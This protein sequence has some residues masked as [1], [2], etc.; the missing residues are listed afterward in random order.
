MEALRKD[1]QRKLEEN[2]NNDMIKSTLRVIG[3][4]TRLVDSHEQHDQAIQFATLT[5]VKLLTDLRNQDLFVESELR[6]LSDALLYLVPDYQNA[7]ARYYDGHKAK[8]DRSEGEAG[9]MD[10]DDDYESIK[11]SF[12]SPSHRNILLDRTPWNQVDFTLNEFEYVSEL[13][14]AYLAHLLVFTSEKV[15]PLG[16][17]MRSLL[18]N[19]MSIPSW[20][21]KNEPKDETHKLCLRVQDISH[22]VF[23]DEVCSAAA[24]F[25]LSL[26]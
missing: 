13:N 10:D 12:L 1:L 18:S 9:L 23:W 14:E 11:L 21:D 3:E 4:L 25:R 6:H 16:R 15:L 17:S 19:P 5:L 24:T 26:T 22:R 2:S 7:N 20:N 8:R